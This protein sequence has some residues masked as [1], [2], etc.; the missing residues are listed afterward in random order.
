MVKE[1]KTK[2]SKREERKKRW[3]LFQKTQ[4]FTSKGITDYQKWDAFTDSEN[5]DEEYLKENPV[6]PKDNPEF[7]IMEKDINERNQRVKEN[8]KISNSL[9][10]KG[11]DAFKKGDYFLA[12]E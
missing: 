5:S 2:K 9:K 4:N 3:E 1:Y 11:N 10:M 12:I 8:L 7:K 6:L